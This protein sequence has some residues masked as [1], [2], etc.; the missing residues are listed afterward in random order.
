M[1]SLGN[2]IIER[3]GKAYLFELVNSFLAIPDLEAQDSRITETVLLREDLY[4][5]E[6][7]AFDYDV[8]LSFAGEDRDYAEQIAQALKRSN[9]KVFYFRF[10]KLQEKNDGQILS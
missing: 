2:A 4:K 10:G 7:D 6:K 5:N 9:I 8:A 1:R 3:K